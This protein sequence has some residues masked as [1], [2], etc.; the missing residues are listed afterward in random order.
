MKIA[1]NNAAKQEVIL[2]NT[3][4]IL[5]SEKASLDESEQ[6]LLAQIESYKNNKKKLIA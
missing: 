4:T 6:T 3:K 1:K 5:E 2:T